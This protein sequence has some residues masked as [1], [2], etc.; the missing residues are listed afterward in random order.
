MPKDVNRIRS[1]AQEFYGVRTEKTFSCCET[2]T[3]GRSHGDNDEF[4]SLECFRRNT[5]VRSLQFPAHKDIIKA[6]SE[7]AFA[8]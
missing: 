1:P 6:V 8:A 4:L 3:D 5:S 7:S 2:A